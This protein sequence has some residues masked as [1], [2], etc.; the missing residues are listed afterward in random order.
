M[1]QGKLVRTIFLVAL[2]LLV[3]ASFFAQARQLPDGDVHFYGEVV[4]GACAVGMLSREQIVKMGSVGS[5]R[6]KFSGDFEDPVPFDITL[7]DC[8]PRVSESVGVMFSGIADGKDPQIF[9]IG[10]GAGT[11]QGVGLGLFDAH[12]NLL[13]PGEAPPW[14][15]PLQEGKNALHYIARYRSTNNHV[16]AG[17]ARVQIWFNVIYP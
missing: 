6:F 3:D 7:L 9:K 14:F 15:T 13:I 8:D 4:S 5:S 10:Y 1:A 11:A 12:E 17:N 2:S 16:Q